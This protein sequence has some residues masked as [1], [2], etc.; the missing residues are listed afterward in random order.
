MDPHTARCSL[1]GFLLATLLTACQ[2]R[3]P[4]APNAG[5]S[6]TTHIELPPP[7]TMGPMTLEEALSQRQSVRTYADSPEALSQRQSVRTYADSPLSL[8]EIAQLFWAA[9]GVTRSWGGRTAPSAGALYPLEVYAA[10]AKGV[11]HYLPNSHRAEMSLVGDVRMA[12]WA[13]GLRQECLRQAPAIFVI[14]VVYE[15]TAG[16]YGERAERYVQLEAGHA[17]QNLLLQ[18]AALGLGAVPIGAFDDE[19]VT[20]ALQLPAGQA[21]L[22]LIPV[23]NPRT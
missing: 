5:D 7:R 9:Q 11:Y 13:A 3:V 17:A 10:T 20:S 14:A 16:K 8:E 18:A 21:P 19:S 1:V 6:G 4:V 23:G 2:T 22:Y 15:R 12:L